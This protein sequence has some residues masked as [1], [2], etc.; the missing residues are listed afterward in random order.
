MT[1]LGAVMEVG[2]GI[3][4]AVKDSTILE[5]AAETAK[6]AATGIATAAHV[7]GV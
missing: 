4:D 6:T 3:I 5:T 7:V 1:G 2:G